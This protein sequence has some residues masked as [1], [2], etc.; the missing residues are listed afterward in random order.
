MEELQYL[1]ELDMPVN[2]RTIK[3]PFKMRNQW[4]AKAH[5]I[6]ERMNDR[7][8]I[9]DLVALIERHVKILSDHLF[10]N[11]QDPGLGAAGPKTLTRFK[12]QPRDRIKESIVA[13]TVTSTNMPQRTEDPRKLKKA[14]YLCFAH[15]MQGVF[16]MQS[17]WA[18]SPYSIKNDNN[19]PQ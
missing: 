7:A 8:H 10:G 4:R 2:M 14:G 15:G 16:D 6:L 11:I 19:V 3:L 13:T 9:K 12:A 18:N 1:Q 5:E 17:L